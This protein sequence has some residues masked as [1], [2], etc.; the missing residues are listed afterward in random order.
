MSDK[1]SL[2]WQWA[3]G[4]S[5]VA[6]AILYG[7]FWG[8]FGHNIPPASPQLSPAD[9]AAFYI[10]YHSSISVSYTH[11]LARAASSNVWL[12]PTGNS[13]PQGL[14]WATWGAEP[15]NSFLKKPDIIG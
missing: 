8:Y 2:K 14:T 4:F 13:A 11:L 3:A 15:E 12:E 7:I 1:A 5:G 6:F 9:L 10:Q